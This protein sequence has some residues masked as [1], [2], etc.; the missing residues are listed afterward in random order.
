MD[1]VVLPAA[2]YLSLIDQLDNRTS[3][4]SDIPSTIQAF[5]GEI[6]LLQA[7]FSGHVG[8]II[9]FSCYAM[10]VKQ[11]LQGISNELTNWISDSGTLKHSQCH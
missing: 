9:S 2:T 4:S 1:V 10:F 3:H 8:I 6:P 7:R 11:F 5:N